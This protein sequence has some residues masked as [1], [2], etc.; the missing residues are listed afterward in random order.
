MNGK[1]EM[2]NRVKNKEKIEIE[3]GAKIGRSV[4]SFGSQR[5]RSSRKVNSL[6]SQAPKK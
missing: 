4:A 3:Q 6:L 1:P 2:K 5:S